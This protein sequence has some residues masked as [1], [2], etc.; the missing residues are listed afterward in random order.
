VIFHIENFGSY[1][2][3]NRLVYFDIGDFDESLLGPSAW[4]PCAA[5]DECPHHCEIAG[6]EA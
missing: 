3:D 1:K 6:A 5:R 4:D 2:G